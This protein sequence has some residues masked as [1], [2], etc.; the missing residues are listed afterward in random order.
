MATKRPNPT[1]PY[2]TAEGRDGP[3][4]QQ[5]H[6]VVDQRDYSTE[7]SVT[8]AV[9]ASLL[10][11]NILAFAALYYK[12]DKRR[13]DV[14]RRCSPQRSGGGGGG[15]LGV[16]GLGGANHELAHSQEEEIMSLQM[17]QRSELERDPLALRTACPPDY[18]L[19]MRRSPDDIPLMTPNTITMIPS[20]MGGT[21]ASLHAFNT[22]PSSGVVPSGP[23]S[24]NNT[25]PH[26]HQH[27][28]S[29]TR[30]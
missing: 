6:L 8:I 12:K 2:P 1:L 19:A 29:T 28:H 11:L 15:G 16:V 9:G 21:L 27:S 14:H 23:G 5:P 4:Q 3:N 18:T 24:Q 7:L 13:H 26:P 17:K 10:F 22:F 20:G 30:V 25:L